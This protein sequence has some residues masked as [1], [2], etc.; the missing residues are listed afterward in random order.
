LTSIE[1]L[2]EYIIGNSYQAMLEE[3][4]KLRPGE[5]R[6][7]MRID[8]YEKEL[9]LVATMRIG[10]DGIEVDFAGTSPVSTYGINVP[11]TYTQAYASFGVRCVV[12]PKIP[13][14]AG[15]LSAVR[16]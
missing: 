5:Y 12:G 10:E 13:N 15:S 8:G 1:P 7:V 6:N 16:V 14:N 3:I 11:L 4:R 2:A 9:D